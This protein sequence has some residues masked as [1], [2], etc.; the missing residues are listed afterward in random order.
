MTGE[1][2]YIPLRDLAAQLGTRYDHLVPLAAREEDPLPVR[3]L[4]GKKRGGFVIKSEMD[5]WLLRN[6]VGY[7][8]R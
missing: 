5:E 8:N 3:Y 6:T 2:A 4:K 7:A 1:A